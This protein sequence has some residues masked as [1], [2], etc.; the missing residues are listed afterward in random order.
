MIGST[1]STRLS[2][3]TQAA[4]NISKEISS[5]QEQATTGLEISKPSDA[6]E[7]V[8]YLHDVSSQ[9]S[10]QGTWTVNAERAMS[11]L[12]AADDALD[13]MS[14]VLSAARE[15]ATQYASDTY[16][17]EDRADGAVEAQAL[18]D[19]LVSLAN[20]E[21]G[22]RYI[23]SGNAYDNE[24]YDAAGTYQGDTDAPATTTG[25]NQEVATGFVGSDLLQSGTDIFAAMATLV[26]GLATDNETYIQSSID[27]MAE[28]G[29][30]I[31]SARTSVG[32][33]FNAADDAAAVAENMQALLSEAIE[34][35][36][37]ADMVSVY[38]SLSELQSNYEAILQM[39][40]SS[41]S[42]NL[43]SMM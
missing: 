33:E 20:T 34:D 11:Y 24:A 38:T 10:D 40:A 4:G 27:T 28:A 22:G 26:E 42:M 15:L 13:G 14:D 5:L 16:T 29:E 35:R 1:Y 37:G 43:F 31:S 12:D 6:P 3:L 8:Q 25:N 36:A 41:Q 18:L 32:A 7:Q 9:L 39:T 21:L 17:T 30:Q 23:F 2:S 19:Q